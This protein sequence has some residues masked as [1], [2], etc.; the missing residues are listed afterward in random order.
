[1]KIQN[2]LIASDHAGYDL[3]QKIINHVSFKEKIKFKDL[4]TDSSERVDY[5]DYA[6]RLT[7]ELP[8]Q[9]DN[10]GILICASGI[11]MSIAANRSS[12]VRAALCYN[13][14]LVQL[15]RAHN[16]ANVLVLGAKFINLNLAIKMIEVFLDTK[17]EGGR[18]RARIDKIT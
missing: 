4:G 2:I 10:I 16:D 9:S 7:E 1:M 18:H 14:E 6:K 5:P 8:E 11:G 17:F 3:K 12:G 13:A 15:A